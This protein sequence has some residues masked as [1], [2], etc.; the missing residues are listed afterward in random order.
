MY[1]GDAEEK[2]GYFDRDLL[3]NLGVIGTPDVKSG[4]CDDCFPQLVLILME[5]CLIL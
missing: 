2:W 5:K 3:E 1:V 4:A